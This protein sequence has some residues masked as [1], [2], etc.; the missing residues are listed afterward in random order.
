M[1]NAQCTMHNAQFTIH[2]AQFL[3]PT[4]QFS[5]HNLLLNAH[6]PQSSLQSTIHAVYSSQ[7]RI[8]PHVDRCLASGRRVTLSQWRGCSGEILPYSQFPGRRRCCVREAHPLRTCRSC[9]GCP[10]LPLVISGD[11]EAEGRFY[12]P[13]RF[14]PHSL[15]SFKCQS[16][17]PLADHF[18]AFPGYRPFPLHPDPLCLLCHPF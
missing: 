6:R 11:S 1:H 5:N 13:C 9:H 17:V 15:P 2:N 16:S 8:V 3:I 4:S 10:S 14:L 12:W 7:L 18:H